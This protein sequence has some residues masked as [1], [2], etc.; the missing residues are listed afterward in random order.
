MSFLESNDVHFLFVEVNGFAHPSFESVW[1]LLHGI[2]HGG[3][4]DVQ[5]F[6]KES[7]YFH[8]FPAWDC[9]TKLWNLE[10]YGWKLSSF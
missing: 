3:N 4:L 2:D 7:S 1:D 10:R 6:S 9:T 5:S 8:V